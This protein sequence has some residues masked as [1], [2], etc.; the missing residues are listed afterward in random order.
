MPLMAP[1]LFSFIL[2]ARSFFIPC[3]LI[4]AELATSFPEQGG[5]YVWVRAA[6]G[7]SVGFVNI[8]LQWVYNVVWYPTILSFI[9]SSIAYLTHPDLVNHRGYMVGM[10]IGC[11]GAAT[12]LNLLGMR[13]SSWISEGGAVIGTMLPLIVLIV[14]G[15]LWLMAGHPSAISFHH[16][17]PTAQNWE[18]ISFLVVVMFSLFGMEMSAVHAS[19]VKNPRRDY[20]RA[21]LISAIFIVLSM[22]LASLAIAVVVP[23]HDL[24][25]LAGVNQAFLAFLTPFHITWMMPLLIT[26]I[27]IGGFAGL[28]TWVIG[29]VKGLLAAVDEGCAPRLFGKQNRYGAPVNLLLLQAAMVL[30]LCAV[31]LL[32]PTVNSAYWL[33]SDLTAQISLLYYIILFLA[34]IRLRHKHPH[35]PHA[36]M[37]PGG[38]KV[39]YWVAGSG[40]V[41]CLVAMIM[42]FIPPSSLDFGGTK[43]YE[44]TLIIGMLILVL[45]PIWIYRRSAARR[46]SGIREI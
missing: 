9:A 20:P 35:R 21:L 10:V 6:F 2:L 25:V 30:I 5:S 27:V 38:K 4:A 29:P 39:F 44:F 37:I 40:I 11:F 26:L 3:T 34:A 18:Q 7:K 19:E 13:I 24:N 41:S 8:W 23:F 22:T 36:F 46:S 45:P 12:V 33:L 14:L 15:V 16:I 32:S 42:G 1:P 43:R 28:A 31:F 17:L